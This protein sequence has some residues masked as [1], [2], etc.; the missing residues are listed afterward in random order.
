VSVNTRPTLLADEVVLERTLVLGLKCLLA[1]W[2]CLFCASRVSQARARLVF[3]AALAS[4][5]QPEP[6]LVEA[7]S[8]FHLLNR[9]AI[10]RPLY[11][12]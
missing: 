11:V 8:L 10:E 3:P 1:R 7:R 6:L 4:P 12:L 9:V 5:K 2:H